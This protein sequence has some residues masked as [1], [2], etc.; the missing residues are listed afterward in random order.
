MPPGVPCLNFGGLGHRPWGSRSSGLRDARTRVIARVCAPGSSG[1]GAVS[2]RGLRVR[3]TQDRGGL[4]PIYR[5]G[6]VFYA[7]G[8]RVW[9]AGGMTLCGAAHARTDALVYNNS[10]ARLFV[11][12]ARTTA[13]CSCIRAA[14]QWRDG[15]IGVPIA[16]QAGRAHR[17]SGCY[18]AKPLEWMSAPRCTPAGQPC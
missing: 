15:A 1:A 5:R 14:A 4:R 10:K 12:P 16:V 9:G 3:S 2:R 8:G 18:S 11:F 17:T 6:V 13:Q 7:D